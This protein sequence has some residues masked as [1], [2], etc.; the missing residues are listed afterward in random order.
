VSPGSPSR[1]SRGVYTIMLFVVTV[2]GLTVHAL[3]PASAVSMAFVD[4]LHAALAFL[5]VGLLAPGLRQGLR[6]MGIAAVFNVTT[7]MMTRSEQNAD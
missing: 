1:R 2:L 5:V 6:P 7:E 4:M 3:Q